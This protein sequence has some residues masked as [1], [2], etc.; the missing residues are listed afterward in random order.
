ML[1][2]TAGCVRD[3]GMLASV[4]CASQ[5]IKWTVVVRN[6]LLEQRLRRGQGQC[7]STA[8]TVVRCP[9]VTNFA[10]N[11]S[12]ATIRSVTFYLVM[13]ADSALRWTLTVRSATGLIVT[14]VPTPAEIVQS[15][16]M[17]IGRPAN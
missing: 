5:A 10:S 13:S 1:L 4:R 16:K 15:A 2:R 14:M 12:A 17:D 6:A 3:G 7:Q 9:G 8:P 11:V